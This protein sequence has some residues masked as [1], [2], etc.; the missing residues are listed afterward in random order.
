MQMPENYYPKVLIVEDDPGIV[1][2][3]KATLE[4]NRYRVETAENGSSALAGILSTIPDIIL[5]DLG[6][7][8]MDGVEIIRSV[9]EWSSIPILVISARSAEREKA[10]ALDCG[11]DDYLTKPF[12]NTEL[13]ARIRTALRHYNASSLQTQGGVFSV[14]GLSVDFNKHKV[15]VD[16]KDTFLTPNE[17]RI[18]AFLARNA[19]Q[20]VTYKAIMR[21][22]WGPYVNSDNKALRVHMANARRKIEPS[23][24]EPRYIFTE[25]GVGY[26]LA[27]E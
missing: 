10:E 11:A 13:L 7:P 8:D 5:L 12:G 22:I 23:L 19:G 18:I 16:G 20:V 15:F 14:R 3:L 1:N 9:R 24:N 17:Y 4:T 25:I 21:E 27:D 6:L 2:Y 26:R